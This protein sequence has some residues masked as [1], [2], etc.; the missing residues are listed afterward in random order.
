[1]K[2]VCGLGNPGKKY[3]HTR[4]NLGFLVI[5]HIAENYGLTF[6]KNIFPGLTG[7]VLY[8]KEKIVLLKSTTYMNNSGIA[9]GG[10]AGY[11]KIGIE[12]I[13]I[14]HDDLDLPLGKLRFRAKGSSGGHKGLDS[15][16]AQLGTDGV[17]RLKIGINGPGFADAS[18]FVL[19]GFSLEEAAV[20]PEVVAAGAKAVSVWVEHGIARAMQDFNGQD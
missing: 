11:F 3:Q 1:M 17:Q 6:K 7:S 14:V 19:K 12:D 16:C 8:G 18:R 10:C 9:V 15:I 5:E 4:H 13:L 20:V 2:L